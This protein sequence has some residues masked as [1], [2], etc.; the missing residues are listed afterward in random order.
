MG[1]SEAWDIFLYP[2]TRSGRRQQNSF[3]HWL[4]QMKIPHRSVSGPMLWLHEAAAMIK[5]FESNPIP[6]ASMERQAAKT[7]QTSLS[8]LIEAHLKKY[9]SRR[10]ARAWM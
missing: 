7:Q 6:G 2:D 1:F 8:L 10:Q 4:E 9:R 3:T 5:L